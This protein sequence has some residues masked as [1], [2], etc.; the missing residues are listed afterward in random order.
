M[1][2]DSDLRALLASLDPRLQPGTYVFCDLGPGVEPPERVAQMVFRETEGTTVV[3]R[4]EDAATLGLVGAFACE[5][6]IVGA[7]SELTAVGFLAALSSALADA[8]L[9]AN[10]VSAYH[11]D[12]LFV[13]A[14]RGRE[15][16]LV[17]EALQRN[18]RSPG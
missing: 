8:G 4:T 1:P 5:W 10:A 16:V 15:A 7:A 3:L 17:L 2:G 18:H 6:I 14:G 11:H 9:S 13:P 12:H